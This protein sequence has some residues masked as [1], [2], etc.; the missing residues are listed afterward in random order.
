MNSATAI[1]RLDQVDPAAGICRS[2]SAKRVFCIF[3]GR[4]QR[5]SSA[6]FSFFQATSSGV[7]LVGAVSAPK[8]YVSPLTSIEK[9]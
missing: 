5:Q 6:V 8:S 9:E 3:S 1:D 4:L 7:A 2:D